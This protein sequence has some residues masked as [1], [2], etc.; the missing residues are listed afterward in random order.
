MY[1]PSDQDRND[2][3]RGHYLNQTRID[4]G[5]SPVIFG[6]SMFTV[7]ASPK[8]LRVAH[9]HRFDIDVIPT[10]EHTFVCYVETEHFNFC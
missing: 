8:I 1:L 2:L 3:E 6:I 9:P 5:T 4:T 10:P 7:V